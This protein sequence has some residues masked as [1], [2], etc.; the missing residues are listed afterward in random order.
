MPW[1]GTLIIMIAIVAAFIIAMYFIQKRNKKRMDESQAQIDAT[2]QVVSMLVIDKKK[3]RLKDSG[4]PAV[5]AEQMPKRYAIRKMPI[6]KAKV[7]PRIM[8]FIADQDIFDMIPVKAEVKATVSGLYIVDV[9]GLRTPLEQKS[10][11]KKKQV[12][13]ED[14]KFDI[15]IKKGRGEM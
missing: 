13:K 14:S 2:K 5:V 4:L 8:S 11:K 1:W 12:K 10:T 15:L 9:R 7:G 3:V 6:V